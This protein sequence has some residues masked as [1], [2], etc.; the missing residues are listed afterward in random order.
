LIGGVAVNGDT[1]PC[2]GRSCGC[3]SPSPWRRETRRSPFFKLFYRYQKIDG[4][5]A[6]TGGESLRDPQDITDYDDTEIN[7][8]G[9]N[10]KWQFTEA[11]AVGIGGFWEKYV[12]KDSAT[13]EILNY[14]PGSFFLK[15]N[16]GDYSSW[17][18]LASLTYSFGRQAVR[19]IIEFLVRPSCYFG[20]ATN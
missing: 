16:D 19:A 7:H 5:N 2:S 3:P 1:V 14:M 10:L 12:I 6:F 13:G 20:I 18:A 15:L 17:A 4:N 9:A 11:W 8:L